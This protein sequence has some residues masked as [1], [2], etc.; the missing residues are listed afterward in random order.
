MTL[1]N[2]NI[3]PITKPKMQFDPNNNVIKLC[4]HGMNMEAEGKAEEAHNLFQQ[5]WNEATNDFEKFTSAHYVARHQKSIVDKLKWDETA[6]QLALKLNDENI[7]ASYPS[8]YL[9]IAKCYEDLE[10]PGTA[11]INYQLALSFTHLLPDDGY[12]RMIKSGI[13]KGIERVT[14]VS[15]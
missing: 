8:L 5:A 9:N 13:M 10:D 1:V 6:L 12:G 7:K 2:T 15:C 14:Q 11:R 3:S 4:A